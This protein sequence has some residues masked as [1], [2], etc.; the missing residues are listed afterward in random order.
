[1]RRRRRR[2]LINLGRQRRVRR[3]TGRWTE[4]QLRSRSAASPPVLA[5]RSPSARPASAKAV[6]SWRRSSRICSSGTPSST[7]TT[8]S[9]PGNCLRGAAG[10]MPLKPSSPQPASDRL[11]PPSEPQLGRFP[12]L[13]WAPFSLL[14][15][16]VLLLCPSSLVQDLPHSS[17]EPLLINRASPRDSTLSSPPSTTGKRR[18][19]TPSCP[20]WATCRPS[21][22]PPPPRPTVWSRGKT[23]RRCCPSIGWTTTSTRTRPHRHLPRSPPQLPTTGLLPRSRCA[24]FRRGPGGRWKCSRTAGPRRSGCS[25]PSTRKWPRRPRKLATS[26]SNSLPPYPAAPSLP[27]PP[28]HLTSVPSPTLLSCDRSPRSQGRRTLPIL[29]PLTPKSRSSVLS[30][31]SSLQ[32]PLR[33]RLPSPFVRRYRLLGRPLWTLLC[34]PRA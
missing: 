30:P 12:D 29:P 25:T 24:P 23:E 14:L 1:M 7:Q 32:P 28:T 17:T 33:G 22:Q 4:A 31:V 16:P 21:T 3:S 27:S 19:T 9:R 13:S 8:R 18:T 20:Q 34:L 26:S 10:G 5:R 2:P 11:Y 15:L 6:S